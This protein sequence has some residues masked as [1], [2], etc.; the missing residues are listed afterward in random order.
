MPEYGAGRKMD[1]PLSGSAIALHQSQPVLDFGHSLIVVI[2]NLEKR[3]EPGGGK[4]FTNFRSNA[5]EA[6]LALSFRNVLPQI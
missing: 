2:M 6:D 4:H 3:I 5:G 1:L